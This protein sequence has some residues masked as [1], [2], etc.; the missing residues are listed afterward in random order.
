ML[1]F[2]TGTLAGWLTDDDGVW[3]LK[4]VS[5]EQGVFMVNSLGRGEDGLGVL[6][7]RPFVIEGPTQRF[8]LAGADGTVEATNDGAVNFLLLR[9]HPDGEILRRARP[10][11]THNLAAMK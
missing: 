2:K 10:P 11:G 6:R 3:A 4:P 7:S 5:D 1:A 8:M 9:A